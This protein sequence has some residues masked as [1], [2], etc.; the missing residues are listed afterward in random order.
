M[1]SGAEVALPA[2]G[3]ATGDA[4]IPHG[5]PQPMQQLVSGFTRQI[6]AQT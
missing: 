5:R 2:G 6:P 4:G 3:S 1:P